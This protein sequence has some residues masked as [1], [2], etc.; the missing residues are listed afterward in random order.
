MSTA[1]KESVMPAVPRPCGTGPPRPLPWSPPVT[2]S[3]IAAFSQTGTAAGVIVTGTTEVW[4]PLVQ[5][6]AG[7]VRGELS[8]GFA[9]QV[10]EVAGRTVGVYQQ[11]VNGRLGLCLVLADVRKVGWISGLTRSNATASPNSSRCTPA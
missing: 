5:S 1:A 7:T 8:D 3:V 6:A 10:E 2:E 4:T 9:V 11:A